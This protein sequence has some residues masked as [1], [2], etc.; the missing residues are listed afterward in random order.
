MLKHKLGDDFATFED[1]YVIQ[2]EQKCELGDG[3]R[4]RCRLAGTRN[5]FAEIQVFIHN[6]RLYT[7]MT[8]KE[9]RRHLEMF[10]HIAL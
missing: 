6:S 5:E 10:G 2:F 4:T 3:T 8:W 7:S 9:A 1:G